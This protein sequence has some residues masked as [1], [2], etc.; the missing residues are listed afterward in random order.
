[1]RRIKLEVMQKSQKTFS[2]IK[3]GKKERG[4]AATRKLLYCMLSIHCKKFPEEFHR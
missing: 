3:E 1:L 4:R 2:W